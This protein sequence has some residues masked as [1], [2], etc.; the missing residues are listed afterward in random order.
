MPGTRPVSAT[1]LR[2][3][4]PPWLAPTP[5]IGVPG[6]RN[7]GAVPVGKPTVAR[8]AYQPI[9]THQKTIVA[10]LFMLEISG[11]TIPQ[12]L[13]VDLLKYATGMSA[14][15]SPIYIKFLNLHRSEQG[16]LNK[17]TLNKLYELA[18]FTVGE[19]H[20]VTY[21]NPEGE[22]IFNK[23]FENLFDEIF[24]KMDNKYN[25]FAKTKNAKRAP[26]IFL[27]FIYDLIVGYTLTYRSNGSEQ[28]VPRIEDVRDY[29]LDFFKF[30]IGKTAK[31]LLRE[32]GLNTDDEIIESLIKYGNG[33]N[34][35]FLQKGGGESDDD[36]DELIEL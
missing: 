15:E 32:R 17:Q 4:S 2:S 21:K 6:L 13:K 27:K 10:I 24:E 28:P 1:G 7:T 12:Q 33:E 30:Y 20:A 9:D 5:D 11:V 26:R 25:S 29:Y 34:I 16:Y 22:K 14:K 31:K 19:E 35:G 18:P 3:P 36:Y 23:L 8:I